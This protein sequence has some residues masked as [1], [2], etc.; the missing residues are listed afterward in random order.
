MLKPSAVLSSVLAGY[1]AAFWG[2]YAA[3]ILT[4]PLHGLGDLL[5]SDLIFT[6]GDLLGVGPDG[7]LRFGAFLGAVS[8]TI[9]GLFGLYLV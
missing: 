4:A 6:L 7:L 3:Q 5:R 8:L 1:F 2:I 9:A